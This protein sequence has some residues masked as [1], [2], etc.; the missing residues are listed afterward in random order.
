M[1]YEPR[2]EDTRIVPPEY[3]ETIRNAL[4][5]MNFDELK[6]LSDTSGTTDNSGY[7][8]DHTH[9]NSREDYINELCEVSD[10]AEWQLA[11]I[12]STLGLQ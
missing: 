4:E 11:K 1:I 3:D 5:K 6:L 12:R 9:A 2:P 8:M 7:L 10:K